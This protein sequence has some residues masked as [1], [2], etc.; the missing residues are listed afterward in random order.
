MGEKGL[1]TL[2][3]GSCGN[4]AGAAARDRPAPLRRLATVVCMSLVRPLRPVIGVAA[5][6]KTYAAA[7][8]PLS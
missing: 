8:G 3:Q 6:P 5:V 1:T 7:T 2:R 4:L